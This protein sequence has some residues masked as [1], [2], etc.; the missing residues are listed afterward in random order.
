MASHSVSTAQQSVKQGGGA[1]ASSPP[2][3]EQ[4]YRGK[5]TIEQLQVPIA[6]TATSNMQRKFH[7]N[8]WG[9]PVK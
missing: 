2:V 1:S 4:V 5:S 3:E 6:T 9:R 8:A 7:L